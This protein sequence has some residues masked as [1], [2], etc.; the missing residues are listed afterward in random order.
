MTVPQI[1]KEFEHNFTKHDVIKSVINCKS[2]HG[3]DWGNKGTETIDDEGKLHGY[4]LKALTYMRIDGMSVAQIM[5][6][7]RTPPTHDG[8][9]LSRYTIDQLEP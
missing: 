1:I 7:H 3:E 8:V 6:E 5:Q 4:N 2:T 9:T